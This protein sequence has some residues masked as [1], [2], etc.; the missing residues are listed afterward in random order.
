VSLSGLTS[1]QRHLWP[2]RAAIPHDCNHLA[3]SNNANIRDNDSGL[4]QPKCQYRKIV[5]QHAA[6]LFF[7]NR[8]PRQFVAVDVLLEASVVLTELLSLAAAATAM[9]IAAATATPAATAPALK[10]AKPPSL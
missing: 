1:Q 6:D 10:P 4:F 2:D 7:V 3:A 8:L 5:R 9:A